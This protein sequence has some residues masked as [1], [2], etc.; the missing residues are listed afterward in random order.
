MA[1]GM[2]D[3]ADL[4]LVD[5]ATKMPA[6]LVDY[7]NATSSE[8]T[9]ESVY[10]N[11]K[12][13][14]AIRWDDAR[15]GT[16]TLDT[17]LFDFGLL[18]MVMGSDIKEGSESVFTRNEALVNADRVAK[19][20]AD[21]DIDL[22]TI[23]VIKLKG[24]SNEHTGLP[25]I[26]I[27]SA[28][29]NVPAQVQNLV[30]STDATSAKVTFDRA[31]KADAYEILRDGNVVGTV[32]KTDFTETGLTPA[33]VAKYT[34]VSI[35]SYGKGAKSAV[36]DA[37]LA[38]EGVT[39]FTPH[40]PTSKAESDAKANTPEVI[41]GK[42]EPTYTVVDGKVVFSDAVSV[43]DRYAIY[44]MEMV[45]DVRTL[46][47][48]A[49]TF[50]SNYEIFANATIREENGSDEIVQIHYKNAKPQSNFTLTQS[51]TEPTSLSIVFDLFPVKGIL[52]EMKII[53]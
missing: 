1:Y 11:K 23:S 32:T 4:I 3:A 20:E 52:A 25:L 12:G 40:T 35:N 21:G 41:G 49:E 5:L 24:D 8:W 13:S 46:T 14:R 27:S 19:L 47:I 37:K 31:D 2:K 45:D 48:G 39:E 10:A 42:T 26:N 43:G 38:A 53:N 28:A 51:A 7:A 22:D 44:F 50:P 9:A 16:L 15:Q 36:V 17:E 30:V 34:V 29:A 18:A 33:S 6:L